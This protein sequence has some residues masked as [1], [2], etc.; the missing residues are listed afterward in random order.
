MENN[1]R[2]KQS[3]KRLQEIVEV[4]MTEFAARQEPLGE[5]FEKVLYDSLLHL[6]KKDEE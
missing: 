5:E 1:D 6:Y 4:F 3:D 2:E